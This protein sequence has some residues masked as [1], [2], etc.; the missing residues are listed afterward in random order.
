MPSPKNRPADDTVVAA[1]S[2]RDA[3][4]DLHRIRDLLFGEHQRDT[5]RRLEQLERRMQEQFAALREEL[6]AAVGG[7]S[8]TLQRRFDQALAGTNAAWQKATET[9]RKE[10]SQELS[11]LGDS[12]LDR[13][14]LAGLLGGLANRLGTNPSGADA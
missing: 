13:S 8:T 12:K 4:D 7:E 3:R 14:A 9:L 1:E 2:P 10:L 5:D 6:A 11:E